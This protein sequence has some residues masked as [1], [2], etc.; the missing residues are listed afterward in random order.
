MRDARDIK[1]ERDLS[2]A[3]MAGERIFGIKF[4]HNSHVRFVNDDGAQAEGWIV[5]VGPIEPEPIYTIERSDGDADEEVPE[6]KIE[7]L[8]D[9]HER[10]KT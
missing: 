9:P 5:G 2:N 10:T 3:F 4:R 7:L 8:F 6:S 1:S